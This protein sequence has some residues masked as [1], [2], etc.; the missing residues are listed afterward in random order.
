[1]CF[2]QDVLLNLQKING[3]Q[4]EGLSYIRI[5]IVLLTIKH[6]FGVNLE[7]LLASGAWGAEEDLVEVAGGKGDVLERVHHHGPPSSPL[8][9]QAGLE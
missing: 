9:H 2:L 5:F 8:L 1:M 6:H 7:L 3:C 4:E